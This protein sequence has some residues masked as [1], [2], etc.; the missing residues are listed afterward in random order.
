MRMML[1]YTYFFFIRNPFIRNQILKFK[2]VQETLIEKI[3]TK[4]RMFLF[5]LVK[6]A[7]KRKQTTLF[8]YNF[9]KKVKHNESLVE[10]KGNE[11]LDESSKFKCK[12]C[13]GSF[14][15]KQGNFFFIF[16]LI[17]FQSEFIFCCTTFYVL[18]V[19]QLNLYYHHLAF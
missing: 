8:K 5:E 14:R 7:T 12:T 16:I 15:S 11:F 6:M 17:C 4:H 10:V 1:C 3:K 19:M 2:N 18:T 9:T 13:A